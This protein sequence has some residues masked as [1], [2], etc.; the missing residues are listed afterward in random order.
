M[1]TFDAWRI[2]QTDTLADSDWGQ[3]LKAEHGEQE[4]ARM[5][6][7]KVAH[8][9]AGLRAGEARAI[10]W[11]SIPIETRRA[12]V[13]KSDVR[14]KSLRR[15]AYA[16]MIADGSFGIKIAALA[17]LMIAD[18]DL[19]AHRTMM[20]EVRTPRADDEIIDSA[21]DEIMDDC[22]EWDFISDDDHELLMVILNANAEDQLS[23]ALWAA[24]ADNDR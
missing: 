3:A 23:A 19:D 14:R 17:E 5:I 8:I 18:F 13:R 11:Q 12:I 4:A 6:A 22:E 9:E 20:I 10:A 1:D 24:F 21:I 15:Q 7:A 2:R 16:A